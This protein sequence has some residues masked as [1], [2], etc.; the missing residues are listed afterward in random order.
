[1]SNRI[2]G[3]LLV[4]ALLVV[5][6]CGAD[7]APGSQGGTHG[8]AAEPE[9]P[10][11][12]HKGRLL[13][14]GDFSVELA[15]YEVDVPPEFHA[16]VTRGGVPVPP[17]EVELTVELTRFGGNIE[18]VNFAPDGEYLRGDRVIYEPHSYAVKVT[19]EHNGARHEWAFE[20]FEG[21]TRIAADIAAAMGVETSIAG[22]ATL[23]NVIEVYGRVEPN[24]ERQRAV[25]A[26]FDGTIR[27]VSVSATDRVSKGDALASI[28]SNESLKP[29]TLRA[30]IDGIVAVRNANPGEQTDGRVLFEIVDT[31]TVWAELA[32]F[33][34]QRARVAIGMPVDIVTLGGER[35]AGEISRIN[36]IAQPNQSVLA[37]A[38]LDNP[39]GLLVPGI[40]VSGEI[41]VARHEVPLAVKR[42]G[43]QSFRDYT[44][45]YA[46]IG[47]EYEVKLLELG[48]EDENF[49]EVLGGLEPGTRYVSGN[50]YLIKADIEKSGAAHDH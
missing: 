34:S 13:E 6:G 45:V 33:P 37:H 11:G 49:A 25:T 31:S 2:F 20:S 41:E 42:S 39:D 10:K 47:D 19:A 36:R 40:T 8:E 5:A 50:S 35:Y 16:W 14:D 22:P 21:R 3:L 7:S 23:R 12:P 15:L 18:T 32:V 28:E 43:L 30:P 29:Y 24:R 26:R 48:R 38:V 4:A 44:V 9:A 27:S 1:M 17:R 46:Q